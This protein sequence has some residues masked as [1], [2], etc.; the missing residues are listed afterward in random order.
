MID[1]P[2]ILARSEWRGEETRR[3]LTVRLSA[4]LTYFREIMSVKTNGQY[5]YAS[6]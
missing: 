4:L 3:N 1:K 5:I 2:C 6:K